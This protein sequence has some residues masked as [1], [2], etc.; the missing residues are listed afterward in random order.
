MYEIIDMHSSKGESNGILLRCE[1]REI[2][3]S[4]LSRYLVPVEIQSYI[5]SHIVL[6]WIHDGSLDSSGHSL[7]SH[8][9]SYQVPTFLGLLVLRPR[10]TREGACSVSVGACPRV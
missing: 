10:S 7:L 6:K 5:H 3:R 4:L 8:V 2:H 1:V 9:V